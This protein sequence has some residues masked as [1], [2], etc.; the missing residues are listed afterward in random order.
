MDPA[1]R[2]HNLNHYFGTGALR[3]QILFDITADIFPGEIVISTG[4]SGSGKTTMLTLACG[5]R[6]VQEGSVV[7]LGTE[8]N[9]AGSP[10]LVGV[11]QNI[12]FI[13]QAHNLLGALTATQNVQMSLQLEKDLTPEESKRRS[14]EML[15]AVGLGQRVDHY[16]HQLS[17]GQKQRV[18]IARALVRQPK[19]VLADEPTA[20]LDKASGREVVDLLHNLA[21]K[22][23]CAILLVTHDNRILDVAD[24][25]LTLEDGKISSFVSG[26]GASAGKLLNTFT[27]LQRR[28]ELRRH[29]EG[30]SDQEFTK[31]LGAVTVEFEQL[32]KTLDVANAEAT[33]TLLDQVLEAA[34][35]RI[36]DM[37]HADRTTVYLV[38]QPKNTLYSRIAQHTGDEPLEIR[39]PIGVG[40]AGRVAQ[41]GQTMN[42][43]DPQH[44]PHFNPEIDSRTGYQ[45]RSLLCIPIKGRAGA[46]IGVAQVLNK[47]DAPA[48]GS[49]DERVFQSFVPSL[50]VILETCGRMLS[51]TAPRQL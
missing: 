22:Q 15:N 6:T 21:K 26:I 40:I 7:T 36:R 37:L 2:I 19:V 41:T 13:F 30:L 8:L 47:R 35:V 50:S 14:V 28:G 46:V 18:A 24:R 48:F 11:R 42:V 12:G 38:D 20:A 31:A 16:P 32:L 39:L 33:S 9:G 29:L 45:T 4:P 5:L 44:H 25:I 3:R 17:G 51:A 10:T 49:D 1:I 23:S 27:T 43:D 34:A